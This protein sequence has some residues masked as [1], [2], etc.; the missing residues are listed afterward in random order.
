MPELPEVETIR[1]GLE[2]KALQ[3]TIERVEVRCRKIILR[4]QASQLAVELA[5]QTIEEIRR[6]GKFLVLGT[7]DFILLIHLGMTGQL[8]YWDKTEKDAEAF[9]INPL[10]GLQQAHQHAIDKHTHIII[11][12]TDGNALHYRDVRQFGKWRLYAKEEFGEAQ[13]FWRLGLEPFSPEYTWKGF[14][15]RFGKRNLRIKSLLLDQGF[16]AGVGNIYADEALFEARVH[17]ERRV[18]G[19]SQDEKL[20]LFKAIPKVLRRGIHFGGTTFQ[21]YL[22][23]EGKAGGFQ[24]YLNVY[25]RERQHCRRCESQIQRLVISQRSSHFCPNCQPRRRS[26]T[27]RK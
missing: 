17:P 5:G 7:R 1:R 25:G 19:L 9:S 18:S 26:R 22:N 13:E 24:E 4:P 21:S 15:A 6:R 20:K 2:K 11:Y 14:E 8:T 12:F 10:T 27:L 23:A 3:K 16:V